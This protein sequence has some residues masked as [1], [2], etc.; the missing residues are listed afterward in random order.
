VLIRDEVEHG[1]IRL[2]GFLM[3]SAALQVTWQTRIGIAGE[4]LRGGQC[5]YTFGTTT[6]RRQ[7][8]RSDQDSCSSAVATAWR[9]E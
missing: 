3:R 4:S 7:N 6:P 9:R 2:E 1:F 8:T 5:S